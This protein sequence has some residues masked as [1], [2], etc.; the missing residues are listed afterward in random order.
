LFTAAR[1][2][3]IFFPA[4]MLPSSPT[5]FASPPVAGTLHPVAAAFQN[6]ATLQGSKG[7]GAIDC[8]GIPLRGFIYGSELAAEMQTA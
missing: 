3:A 4:D 8:A 1:A 6:S 5:A 7:R 2:F